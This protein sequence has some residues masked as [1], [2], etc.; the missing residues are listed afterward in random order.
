M[1]INFSPENRAVYEINMKK[2][3]IAG[4]ATDDSMAHAHWILDNKECKHTQNKT[5]CFPLQQCLYERVS[6]LRCTYNACLVASVWQ[7][8]RVLCG[9][10]PI[11]GHKDTNYGNFQCHN[12]VV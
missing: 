8:Y 1:I 11:S 5:Y 3:C 2:Y 10:S 7:V 4:E 12:C 6:I 9:A